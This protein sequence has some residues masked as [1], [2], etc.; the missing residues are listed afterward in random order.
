M[1][2]P[3]C[4]ELFWLHLQEARLPVRWV[5]LMELRLDVPKE[6]RWPAE[7]VHRIDT[8]WLQAD[9]LGSVPVAALCQ[10][11]AAEVH[12]RCGDPE[13]AAMALQQAHDA[14]DGALLSPACTSCRHRRPVS[15]CRQCRT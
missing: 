11:L 9:T 14:V 5:A 8:D 4:C 10:A 1:P 13:A 6:F 12:G 2:E 3:V 7:H 15:L